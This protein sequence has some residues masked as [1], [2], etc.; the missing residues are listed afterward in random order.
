MHLRRFHSQQVD[1]TQGSGGAAIRA[2]VVQAEPTAAT[3]P[4][5]PQAQ[6]APSIDVAAIVAET[7]KQTRDSIFAEMRRNGTL[8]DP[9][10][11]KDNTAR[12]ETPTVDADT[13]RARE[14]AF[15]RAV[16]RL[17]LS[18]GAIDR[19]DKAFRAE[20][21]DDVQGWINGYLSDFGITGKASAATATAPTT[22]QPAA[23]TAK[24]AEPISNA[25]S[26]PASRAAP[27]DLD[28]AS[29]NESDAL[30]VLKKLGAAEVRK[31][32][33]KQLTGRRLKL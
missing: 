24:S 1:E 3:P 4:V 22:V 19:M 7:V 30:A 11:S 26:P 10:P 2:A 28:L 17:D 31:R 27:E 9:K 12:G 16:A 25:G 14:R 33:A 15:D 6:A 13:V 29:L 18:Q 20:S 5:Q 21:P 32:L 8:K 23:P